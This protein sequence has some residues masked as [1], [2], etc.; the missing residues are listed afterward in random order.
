MPRDAPR[1]ERN[2]LRRSW[3]ISSCLSTCG[4]TER[5]KYLQTMMAKTLMLE[6]PGDATCVLLWPQKFLGTGGQPLSVGHRIVEPSGFKPEN[7]GLHTK[8]PMVY[9]HFPRS[10]MEKEMGVNPPMFRSH[11][12]NSWLPVKCI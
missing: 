11:I 6:L 8:N 4:V 10:K 1:V 7:K 5:W 2:A 9:H 12:L 3:N